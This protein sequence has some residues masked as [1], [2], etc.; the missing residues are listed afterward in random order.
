MHTRTGDSFVDDTTT[1][2]T[3]DDVLSLPVGA[4]EQGLSEEEEKLV[5]KV[6]T[7]IEFFLDCLHVTG[8][9]LAPSKCAWYR[10]SHCWKDD[11]P[12]FLQPNP[13]HRGIET[14]SKSTGTT[15]GIKRKAP[16]EGH[17][18]LGFHLEGDGTS[19]AH[20]KVIMDKAVLYGEAIIHSK[21]RRGEIGMAQNSFY[22]PRLAYG[23][24]ATSLT[25][26][27]CTIIQKNGRQCNTAKDGGQ[28]QITACRSVWNIQIWWIRAGSL[29]RGTSIRMDP[30]PHGSP[31]M[32]VRDKQTDANANRVQPVGV[33]KPGAD[34]YLGL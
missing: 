20:K 12:R 34:L 31:T 32:L 15:S 25:L 33:W 29:G 13:T 1:G 17:R 18:T 5:A 16:E 11:I 9:D 8:G 3:N 26:A 14:V 19:I 23:T 6:E 21:L 27:E 28:P 2:A 22:M 10:I 24:P 4:W 7:I 30:V